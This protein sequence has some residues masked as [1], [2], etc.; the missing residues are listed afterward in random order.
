[1]HCHVRHHCIVSNT[2]KQ[3]TLVKKYLENL[4]RKNTEQT[5]VIQ[6]MYMTLSINVTTVKL[7]DMNIKVII[8]SN[9]PTVTVYTYTYKIY[10][11]I[12]GMTKM[13]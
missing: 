11:V 6:V 1:M 3:A 4:P 10:M 9:L 5:S 12:Y 13:E 2:I 7:I 8:C